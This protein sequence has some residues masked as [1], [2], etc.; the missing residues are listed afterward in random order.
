MEGV[1]HNM[2][3][4]MKDDCFI[5]TLTMLMDKHEGADNKSS[6]KKEGTVYKSMEMGWCYDGAKDED[7][8]DEIAETISGLISMFT[9]FSIK[10]AAPWISI[11]ASAVAMMAM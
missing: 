3:W 4:G 1:D 7:D 5:K 8:A 6:E 2:F 11:S 9:D 10:N